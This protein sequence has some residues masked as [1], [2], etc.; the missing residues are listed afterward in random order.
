[1]DAQVMNES[2]GQGCACAPVIPEGRLTSY[3]YDQLIACGEGRMHGPN[4]PPLPVPPMLMF[5]E[6]SQI[7][8]VG[9]V[10]KKGYLEAR[11]TVRPD[12]WFF[13][14]HFKNDPVMPGCLGLDALWQLLGFYLGWRGAEGRGRALGAKEVKFTGQI[15]PENK[16]VIYKIDMVRVKTAPLYMG[17]GDGQVIA[18]GKQLYEVQGL[19][20]GVMPK[21]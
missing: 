13:G 11:L 3:N 14:C 5:D 2:Q 15:L 9:G 10:Y 20:V 16:E 21:G 8:P 4:F 17:I 19:K 12:L 7:D 1:M 6:I 18:D